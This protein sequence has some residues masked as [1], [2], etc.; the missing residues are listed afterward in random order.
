[1]W[2]KT[3]ASARDIHFELYLHVL[4]A[5]KAFRV[6]FANYQHLTKALSIGNKSIIHVQIRLPGLL[7]VD[8]N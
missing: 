7:N 1:M 4:P 2:V 6:A 8:T 5:V 3:R